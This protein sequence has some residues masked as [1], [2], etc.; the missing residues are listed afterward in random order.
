MSD[1]KSPEIELNVKPGVVE[2]WEGFC[3]SHPR[4]SIALD[5]YVHGPPEFCA[6]GPY[7]NFDHH[8]GV[9]RLATRS[10]AGQVLVAIKLGLFDTFSRAGQPVANVFS[11]DCD[12]DI[13]L[14]VWMLQNPDRMEG[15]KLEMDVAQVILCEDFLDA[16]AGVFPVNLQQPV[17]R[18]LVWV[19]EIYEAARAS[20][21]LSEMDGRE[22]KELIERTG[23][24]ITLLWQGR[25]QEC[26]VVGSYE[27]IGGGAGWSMI[28]ETGSFARAK[29]LSDGERAFVAVRDRPDG[30]Y[31]Y[32]IGK[33]SPFVD[34]PIET[35]LDELNRAEG[36]DDTTG[37]WG[38]SD[39]IGGSPRKSGSRMSP[40]EVERVINRLLARIV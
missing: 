30:G 40:E 6:D 4:F 11:N 33:M 18:K 25:G 5:G 29:L 8:S 21:R 1:L 35:I 17:V 9:N 34:F 3:G 27:R 2:T 23:D 13:C 19:F 20:G 32:S 22:M 38:G 10:T 15:L 12:H 37:H 14:A 28:R 31:V 36:S 39:M 24:R 7:A 26:D 16:T